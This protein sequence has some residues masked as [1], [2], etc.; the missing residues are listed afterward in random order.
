MSKLTELHGDVPGV[1]WRWVRIKELHGG[2]EWEVSGERKNWLWASLW[3][4][5]LLSLLIVDIPNK[6]YSTVFLSSK[7]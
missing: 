1:M 7:L 3:L 5:S 6:E 4:S 2:S